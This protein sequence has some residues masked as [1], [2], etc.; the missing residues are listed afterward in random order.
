MLPAS[1]DQGQLIHLNDQVKIKGDIASAINQ[2]FWIGCGPQD[3]DG[4]AAEYLTGDAG[5]R[6]RCTEEFSGPGQQ[7][8]MLL[9]SF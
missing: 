4:G 9:D 7:A 5:I 2:K 3:D 8:S 1:L 6:I